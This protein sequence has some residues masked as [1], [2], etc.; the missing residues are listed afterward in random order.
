[1]TKQEEQLIKLI[2]SVMDEH[3]FNQDNQTLE[4]SVTGFVKPNCV[5]LCTADHTTKQGDTIKKGYIATPYYN[6]KNIPVLSL[7]KVE[8]AR[9]NKVYW[10]EICRSYLDDIAIM[11][12]K[13]EANKK[14]E[15][16]FIL[17]IKDN[18]IKAT[19]KSKAEADKLGIYCFNTASEVNKFISEFPM[20]AKRIAEET[21]NLLK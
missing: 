4:E 8:Y 18:K 6:S 17:R 3:D 10:I 7:N 11:L 16:A 13:A 21:E 20:L 1:M 19:V 9:Y 2:E 5:Y 15:G 12:A 14:N